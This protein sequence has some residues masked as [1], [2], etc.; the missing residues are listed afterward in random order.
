MTLTTERQQFAA[1]NEMSMEFVNW[2]FDHKKDSC[3]NVWF[4][5]A[6]A[7]WEGWKGLASQE[8]KPLHVTDGMALDFHHAL[9]EGS[10]GSDELEEIKVG[11]RA[12]L[13]NVTAPPTSAGEVVVTRNERGVIVAVTRQDGEGQV[14]E[15]IAESN[16]PPAPA[17]PDA[18]D[19]SDLD[20]T[21][22]DREVIEAIAE[23]RGWNAYRAAMLAAAPDGGN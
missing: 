8:A 19:Y 4:M 16:E 9:T 22:Q 20:A 7:M 21:S 13:C 1:Q 15:V 23:C 12:A 18:V 11:L 2:F 17:V 6:A 14:V 5:M 10:I 3:G